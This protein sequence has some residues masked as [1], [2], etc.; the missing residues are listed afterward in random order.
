MIKIQ[1][2]SDK[3]KKEFAKILI[4]K[5]SNDKQSVK[6]WSWNQNK[7]GYCGCCGDKE[8]R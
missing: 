5:N 3:C 6:R 8:Y 2:C 4:T 7:D 1:F